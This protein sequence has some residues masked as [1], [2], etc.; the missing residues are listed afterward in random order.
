M[1]LIKQHL[2]DPEICIRCNTC[3]ESCPVDA[4]SH[5]AN[6]YVVDVTKCQFCLACVPPCPTGAIDNWRQV[7]IPYTLEEQFSWTD[8]PKQQELANGGPEAFE[9]EAESLIAEAHDGTGGKPVAPYTASRPS[10]N[11]YNRDKPAIA[12]VRGN[13]RLTA[14]DAEND[15][16]H[17]ILDFGDQAFPV[18]EGQSI[19]IVPPGVNETGEPNHIRLYSIASPRHGERPN[20]NNLALTL[21]REASGICSNYMCGLKKGDK[22][23]VTGPFGATFLMPNDPM[24]NIV[25]ICTGTGAAPFRGFTEWKRR[26]MPNAPGRLVL[27]FGARRPEELPYFGPLQSV[28]DSLL[29]KFFAYSRVPGQPKTY[30]QDLMRRESALLSDLVGSKATHVYI[31]GLKGM[32]QGVDAA[33]DDICRGAGI[34]WAKLRKDM[35]ETGRYHVET[36]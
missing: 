18:L 14:E 2:I 36:Y 27:F 11:L 10:V 33:F 26:I 23:E 5:D 20:H 4:I 30:V 32:E 6:N 9:D 13:Y 24:A 15:I 31:C 34:N 35:R 17:I 19:G 8:L 29:T 22:V 7:T 12:T 25:M 1:A 21:K 3:E 28:P 16:H